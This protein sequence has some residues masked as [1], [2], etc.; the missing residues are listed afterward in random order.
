MTGRSAALVQPVRVQPALDRDTKT[1][2]FLITLFTRRGDVFRRETEHHVQRW[3]DRAE[4]E[5]DIEAA[6]FTVESVT[7][8]YTETPAAEQTMRETWV[9]RRTG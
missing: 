8:D 6:E 7:D 9:L 1:V 4:L 3:F 2:D 5:A